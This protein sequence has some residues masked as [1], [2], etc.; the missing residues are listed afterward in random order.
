MF[1]KVR[2]TVGTFVEVFFVERFQNFSWFLLVEDGRSVSN[3]DRIG[4]G[5]PFEL[6]A[7]MGRI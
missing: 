2:G 4:K 7:S 3:K 6:Y 1:E 5:L